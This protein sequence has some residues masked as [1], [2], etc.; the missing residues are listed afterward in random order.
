MRKSNELEDTTESS[1]CSEKADGTQLRACAASLL[2]PEFSFPAVCGIPKGFEPSALP[3][4]YHKM[5]E[6]NS[7]ETSGPLWRNSHL[8]G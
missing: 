7:V 4:K 6:N 1:F 5:S 3:K 8:P 2:P